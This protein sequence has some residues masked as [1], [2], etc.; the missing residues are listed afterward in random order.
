MLKFIINFRK[1][2]NISVCNLNAEK[3]R[4]AYGQVGLWCLFTVGC[5]RFY[6]TKSTEGP[7]GMLSRIGVP[8]GG[9]SIWSVASL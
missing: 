8:A 1:K 9:S 2:F 5:V 6:Q 7:F 3:G 4:P